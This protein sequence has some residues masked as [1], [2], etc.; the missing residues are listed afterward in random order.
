MAT[1]GRG[2]LFVDVEIMP[3]GMLASENSL[4]LGIENHDFNAMIVILLRVRN[5]S[6]FNVVNSYTFIAALNSFERP[7][8]VGTKDKTLRASEFRC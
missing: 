1:A 4:P 3:K 5:A 8:F 2:D 7:C 6:V